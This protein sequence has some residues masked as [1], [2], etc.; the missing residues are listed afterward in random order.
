V[1]GGSGSGFAGAGGGV[2]AS[3]E[4]A[5]ITGKTAIS[6]ERITFP[7]DTFEDARRFSGV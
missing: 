1:T 2:C 3:A 5:S 6:T 4:T 7:Q